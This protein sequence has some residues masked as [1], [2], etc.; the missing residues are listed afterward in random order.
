MNL[1]F[2]LFALYLI[3][4]APPG[5]PVP[6]LQAVNTAQHATKTK[7]KNKNITNE[8]TPYSIK[9]TVDADYIYACD[10]QY[11]GQVSVQ[12]DTY[13]S[14]TNLNSSDC[15]RLCQSRAICSYCASCNRLHKVHLHFLTTSCSTTLPN[16]GSLALFSH[17]GH[18]VE[19]YRNFFLRHWLFTMRRL[20]KVTFIHK[21]RYMRLEN[22]P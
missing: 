4:A 20:F 9:D 19:D 10:H 6:A 5:Q 21:Y 18:G 15:I 12:C 11:T 13:K 1:F 16:S 2:L 3:S 7:I 17:S 8:Q 14:D 22:K